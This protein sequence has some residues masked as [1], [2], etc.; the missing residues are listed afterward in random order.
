MIGVDGQSSI[1]EVPSTATISTKLEF[2]KIEISIEPFRV[3]EDF[4]STG[5]IH[6][7]GANPLD[8]DR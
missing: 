6:I 7:G 4:R 2:G 5:R 8:H 3:D 1:K